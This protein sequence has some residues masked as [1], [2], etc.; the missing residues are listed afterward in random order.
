[1]PPKSRRDLVATYRQQITTASTEQPKKER[2]LGLLHELFGADE[3]AKAQLQNLALGSETW[4]VNIQLKDRSKTGRA[5]T[6]AGQTIIE[7]ENDLRKTVDQLREYVYGQ[8]Q[9]GECGPFT[10]LTTDCLTWRVYAP[11][12]LQLAEGVESAHDLDLALTDEIAVGDDNA[13]DFYYFLDRY[14]FATQ[15]IRPTLEGLK[16]D[17][18]ETSGVFLH[19]LDALRAHL[20]IAL[21]DGTVQVAYD[22]WRRMLSIAYGD[23]FQGGENDFLVHTYL[24][25]LAKV[26]AYEV[27]TRDDFI[28]DKELSGLL[29]GKIFDDLN[30]HNFVE[31]DF[32]AWVAEPEH[33]DAL[34][35]AFRAITQQVGRYDFK[36]VSENILKGVYQK[37]IDLDTHHALG[38]YYT[39]DWLCERVVAELP[40]QRHSRILDPAC[41]S[42]SFL[43]AADGAA[44]HRPPGPDRKG[45][46]GAGRRD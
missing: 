34:R 42:G 12:Y 15:P 14:L 27:L 41:G 22:Q 28:D 30:V 7:F 4:V 37:L 2:L 39:P 16:R 1:M 21:Q 32:F 31:Q 11:H 43:R 46:C 40:I 20:D 10:L 45:T 6:I 13:D 23:T 3:S 5:D 36:N 35:P 29:T 24:S 19:A 9:A 33:L 38:E 25:V 44:A 8:W 18:G 26:L 17:F